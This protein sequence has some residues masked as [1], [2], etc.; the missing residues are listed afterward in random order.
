MKTKDGYY[1]EMQMN[2][3]T[4]KSKFVRYEKIPFKDKF[5]DFIWEHRWMVVILICVGFIMLFY[6]HTIVY[7][8]IDLILEGIFLYW[9]FNCQRT[10]EL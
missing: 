2:M 10:E 4:G 1:T 9:W 3:K 7:L 6:L 5:Y 8:I